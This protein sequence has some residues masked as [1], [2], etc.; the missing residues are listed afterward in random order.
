MSHVFNLNKFLNR[1]L[2]D[3]SIDTLLRHLQSM[4]TQPIIDQLVVQKCMAKYATGLQALR[5]FNIPALG[6]PTDW[7][8][9]ITTVKRE[10]GLSNTDC[11]K[12][13]SKTTQGKVTISEVSSVCWELVALTAPVQARILPVLHYGA[14][15][16]EIH[17]REL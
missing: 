11:S 9:L 4:T 12:C 16:E 10:K 14:K 8:A 1:Q 5:K 7:R 15:C 3:E 6:G 13:K 17:K 2:T